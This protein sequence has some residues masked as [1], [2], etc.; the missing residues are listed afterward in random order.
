[1]DFF[2]GLMASPFKVKNSPP[3]LLSVFW[4]TTANGIFYCWVDK[5]VLVFPSLMDELGPKTVQFHF[6]DFLVMLW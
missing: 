4:W 5:R 1:M 2:L 3:K 6:S